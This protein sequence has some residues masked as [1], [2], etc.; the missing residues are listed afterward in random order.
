MSEPSP[1]PAIASSSP[2]T[3]TAPPP[4]PS[5][6]PSRAS[7][8]P[9]RRDAVRNRERILEAAAE[10][11]ARDGLTVSLNDIARYAGIGVGTVYRHF[12][13]RDR[14]IEELFEAR[15]AEMIA[16]VEAGLGDPDPWRGLTGTLERIL[17]MQAADRGLRELFHA[18]EGGPARIVRLRERLLPVGSELLAR[19]QAAGEIR[20]DIAASDLPLVQIM[21][22]AVLD[23]GREVD[24][25]LWRR[26]LALLL[27]GMSSDPDRVG[28]LPEAAPSPDAV[29]QVIHASGARER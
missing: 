9:L 14:L 10:L 24:P 29:D 11:F 2:P 6:P 4:Q 5:G 17:E 26:Y 22:A 23:A 21:A 20:E 1:R 13:D 18:A 7:A 25:G 19:A 12:P 27:P 16:T 15:A 3:A 28:P 8:R